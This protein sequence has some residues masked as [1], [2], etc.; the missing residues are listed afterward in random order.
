MEKI[1]EGVYKINVGSSVYYLE[2]EKILIDTG[3]GSF[4]ENLKEIDADAVKKV[5]FTHLHFDHVGNFNLF[6]NAKF[7]ASKKEIEYFRKDALGAVLDGE[8]AK[9]F[10]VKLNDV[11]EL[12]MF[13]IIET[14]GHT[15]GSICLLYKDVLFSGDTLFEDGF[16]RV[17]LPSSM[18]EEMERSLKKLEKI[19][20]KCLCPGHDY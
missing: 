6:K 7:Y 9:W 3:E 15:V 16:G 20:Y 14:P 2:K 5:V 1:V 19:K 17:D 18:P 4:G 12:K 13:K 11:A 8:L 10:R